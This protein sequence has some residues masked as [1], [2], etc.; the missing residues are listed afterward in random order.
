MCLQGLCRQLH[1]RI[2]P[3]DAVSAQEPVIGL[4]VSCTAD[5]QYMSHVK[6]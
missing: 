2:A 1:R 5:Q 3:Q 4:V 6:A